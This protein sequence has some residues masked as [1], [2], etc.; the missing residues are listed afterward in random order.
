MIYVR[1]GNG[2]TGWGQPHPNINI[3]AFWKPHN[4]EQWV[5][6]PRPRADNISTLSE[7]YQ[8]RTATRKKL[9][10]KDES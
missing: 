4:V 3:N 1:R 2:T 6:V 5:V 7:R 9:D 10:D 8:E